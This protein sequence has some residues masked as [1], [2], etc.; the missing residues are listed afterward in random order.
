MQRL[1]LS[2]HRSCRLLLRCLHSSPCRSFLGWICPCPIVCRSCR[3]R[4][5]GRRPAE[6]QHG[7][8]ALRRRDRSGVRAQ[9]A[10]RH[11]GARQRARALAAAR[12][13]ERRVVRSR[14]G[15]RR[16]GGQ[17]RDAPSN[18]RGPRRAA[19]RGKTHR[20][21]AVLSARVGR[22]LIE[23]RCHSR[24][25]GAQDRSREPPGTSSGARA[26]HAQYMS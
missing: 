15:T 26:R 22:G 16:R 17:L 21:Q 13:H 12:E 14:L 4:S 2:L 20:H 18:R 5:R 10:P 9:V 7:Q 23:F 3:R 6:R 11:V 25:A 1:R 19:T 24:S 8:A